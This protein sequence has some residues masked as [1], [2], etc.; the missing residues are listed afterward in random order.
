MRL[1]CPNCEA[2]YE[3]P[4]DAIPDAGRDVQCANCGHAW[5]QMRSRSG[6]GAGSPDPIAQPTAG[7]AVLEAAEVSPPAEDLTADVEAAVA[8]PVAADDLPPDEVA[9]T[10]PEDPAPEPE[11]LLVAE[12]EAD[13]ESVLEP[14]DEPQEES[15]PEL[16]PEDEAELLAEAA[17]SSAPA[18]YAVDESVLAILREEAER[19]ASVRRGES[20]PLE[21]QSELGIDAAVAAKVKVAPAAAALAAA[22]SDD[23]KPSARRDLLPDVEEINSTLRPAEHQSEDDLPAGEIPP[24]EASGGFRSGFLLVMTVAI[25][26]AGL[27]IA[28]PTVGRLVPG[29]ASTMESYI[30]VVDGFRLRLD[31]VMQ[32]ATVALNGD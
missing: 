9:D 23:G 6:S 30:A 14:E 17:A 5:Y 18:G 11:V 20:R 24:P 2:K 25:I 7:I 21:T 10:P 29:L 4:D 3:V 27:Y 32:S 22:L 8:E 19:E 31:G 12:A 26:G 16:E 13:V 15:E 28:A 1:V